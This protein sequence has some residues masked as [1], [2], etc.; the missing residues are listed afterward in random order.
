[1]RVASWSEGAWLVGEVRVLLLIWRGWRKTCDEKR[2]FRATVR[3]DISMYTCIHT[4][5]YITFLYNI[6]IFFLVVGA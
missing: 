1:M 6:F 5:I 4:Y 3:K 2:R